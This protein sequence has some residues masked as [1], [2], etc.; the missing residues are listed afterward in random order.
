MNVSI[1]RV[2]WQTMKKGTKF[3]AYVREP[4]K[5]AIGCPCRLEWENPAVITATDSA[6]NDRIFRK[7]DFTFE[8]LKDGKEK[9]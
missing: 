7:S 1:R 4:K 8:E 5:L 2:S 3:N 9:N 6:G